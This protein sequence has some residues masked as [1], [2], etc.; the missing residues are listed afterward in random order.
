[1]IEK[2]V[3]RSAFGDQG[4]RL[5]QI[6]IGEMI[7]MAR[8]RD[9]EGQ[10]AAVYNWVKQNIRY[11]EDPVALDLYPTA[12]VTDSLGGGDCDDHVIFICSALAVIGFTTGCR[13]IRTDQGDWHIYALVWMTKAQPRRAVAIDTTWPPSKGPGHEFPAERCRYR[14]SW[15]FNFGGR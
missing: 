1:M 13:V 10:I 11:I 7:P 3:E 12:L 6:V 15:V 4:V 2:M 14:K 5:R 8:D 9:D